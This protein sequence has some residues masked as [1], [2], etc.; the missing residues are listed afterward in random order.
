M[1][2]WNYEDLA[3][4][5]DKI[6]KPKF[7]AK[8]TGLGAVDIKINQLGNR[9]A[10]SSID[11]Q[12]AIFNLHQES[13]LTHYKDIQRFDSMLDV[14]KIDFNPSGSEILTGMLSLKLID[15]ASGSVIKEFN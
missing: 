7:E 14:N 9:I 6:D 15:V 8:G 10:V 12:L 3:K 4:G 5:V 1:R 13:G 2:V 11:Y